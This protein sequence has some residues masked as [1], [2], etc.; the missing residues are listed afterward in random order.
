MS[1]KQLFSKLQGF[2]YDLHREVPSQDSRW[3]IETFETKS[4]IWFYARQ[5]SDLMKRS[6]KLI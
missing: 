1:Y 6:A 4:I 2:I 5:I 3:L